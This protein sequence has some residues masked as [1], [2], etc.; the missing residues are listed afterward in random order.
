MTMPRGAL[1]EHVLGLDLLPG[2]EVDLAVDLHVPITGAG[3][4]AALDDGPWLGHVRARQAAAEDHDARLE[5]GG[6]ARGLDAILVRQDPED[7]L[8]VLGRLGLGDVVHRE[9]V[10]RGVGSGVTTGVG[11]TTGLVVG[12]TTA[13]GAVVGVTAD[14]AAAP[15]LL[16]AVSERTA[17]AARARGRCALHGQAACSAAGCFSHR[18]AKLR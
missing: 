15:A 5:D 7:D 11:V 14:G 17:N 4:R 10:G 18:F 8:A 6:I 12:G 13:T 2:I 16:Q 1:V 9:R 3:G